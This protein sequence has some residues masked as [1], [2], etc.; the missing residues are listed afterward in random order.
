M[1]SGQLCTVAVP[2]STVPGVASASTCVLNRHGFTV[3]L[4]RRDWQLNKMQIRARSLALL[5][6]S[7]F[8]PVLS[9]KDAP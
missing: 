7:G 1:E 4:S 5:P 2:S 9:G 6:S 8:A 3:Y